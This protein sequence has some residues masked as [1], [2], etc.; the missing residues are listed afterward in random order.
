M[1][2]YE[3]NA[4]TLCNIIQKYENNHIHV[5]KNAKLGTEILLN[6]ANNVLDA[7]K[8]RAEKM[9][10]SYSKA[11]FVEIV[12]KVLIINSET[13]KANQ[14]VAEAVIDKQLPETLWIDPSRLLQIMMNLT[15]NALKFTPKGGK[16][17]ICCTWH[18]MNQD[19]NLLIS[20]GR[21]LLSQTHHQATVLDR[22]S[23]SILANSLTVEARSNSS[24]I[25]RNDISQEFNSEEACNRGRNFKSMKTA[26]I[27]T[28]IDKNI[29][30]RNS[31]LLQSQGWTIRYVPSPNPR[32]QGPQ[33]QGYL[34]VEVSD[35]GYG[36]PQA[37]RDVC[38]G[39]PE[40]HKHAW[41]NRPWTLDL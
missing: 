23:R 19:K 41:R 4:E 27:K 28:F 24:D 22:S 5:L 34:K 6:L 9:D 32:P 39:S 13:I 20:P 8:L 31:S 12:K 1:K 15:S 16:V 38:A 14:I 37:L 25:S 33:Q 2:L 26:E 36:I 17:Q 29:T 35:T 18:P 40:C 11:N 21:E 10:I 7:A 30:G 3:D